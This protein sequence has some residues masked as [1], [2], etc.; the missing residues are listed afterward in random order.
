MAI[1]H[2]EALHQYEKLEK[3]QSKE[4][5]EI[6]DH[7]IE[8]WTRMKGNHRFGR[9]YGTQRAWKRDVP[10]KDEDGFMRVTEQMK[11]PFD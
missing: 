8:G 6:M 2:Q 11:I 7:D 3:W 4:Y 1:L 9:T 5:S 10:K